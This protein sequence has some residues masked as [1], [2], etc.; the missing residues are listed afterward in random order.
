VR[1][2][3]DAGDRRRNVVTITEA[4]GAR[5][6]ELDHILTAVQDEVL[7]PLSLDERS[8]LT[9]TLTR[10]LDRAATTSASSRG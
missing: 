2:A 6:R 9:G 1:R 7:A 5:L 3:A 4:G 8:V 10:M